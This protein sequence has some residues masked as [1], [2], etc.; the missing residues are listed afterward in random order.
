MNISKKIL[1]TGSNGFLGKALYADLLNDGYDLLGSVRCPSRFVYGQNNLAVGSLDKNTNWH[2]A[3]NSCHTVVHLASRAHVFND[4]SSDP[5]AEFR[6]VNIDATINLA[7]QAMQQ[8]VKK[9]IYI[10]SIGVYGQSTENLPITLH[11]P[12]KPHSLYAQSKLESEILLREVTKGSG[13]EV[14]VIRSPA[15]YGKD[16]PGNFGLI[17]SLLKKGIYL[18][19]GSINNSRNMIYV[20]NL[21][22]FIS[23]CITNDF[24]NGK[25]LL[26]DDNYPLSTKQIVEIIAYF[27]NQRA[28]LFKLSPLILKIF[29]NC[30]GKGNL[31][32]SLLN[33]YRIDSYDTRLLT[34]WTPP[35]SPCSIL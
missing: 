24:V 32:E 35:F 13:L 14:V 8:G 11:S 30:L 2:I 15:I 18:P 19:F 12:F 29:L 9:F 4:F 16:A 20:H 7:K 3:L 6:K 5:V 10:S 22:N 21:T 25:D 27:S 28:R 1:I 23:H 34:G 17:E 33:D 31:Q 26:I